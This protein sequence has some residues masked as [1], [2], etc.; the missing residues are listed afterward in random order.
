MTL[1]L[2][3]R[4]HK[5]CSEQT[6]FIQQFHFM[7]FC[8]L[9]D[10]FFSYGC[11][12]ASRQEEQKITI[13][14]DE[15]ITQTRGG[16]LFKFFSYFYILGHTVKYKKKRNSEENKITHRQI[17]ILSCIASPISVPRSNDETN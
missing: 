15:L 16:D 1:E 4:N 10:H 7:T 13:I 2:F 14:N 8:N 6:E 11:L 17:F 3:I 5:N 12:N 9:R